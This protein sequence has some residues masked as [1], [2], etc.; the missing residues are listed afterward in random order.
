MRQAWINAETGRDGL[1]RHRPPGTER[2]HREAEGRDQEARVAQGYDEPVP[3]AKRLEQVPF[4]NESLSHSGAPPS[5]TGKLCVASNDRPCLYQ[6][7]LRICPATARCPVGPP[8]RVRGKAGF[9]S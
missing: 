9:P 6:S 3:P 2:A 1:H 5:T 7:C 8:A 4:F